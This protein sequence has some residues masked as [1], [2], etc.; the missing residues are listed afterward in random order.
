[1]EAVAEKAGWGRPLPEGRGRGIALTL[2][3]QTYAAQVVEVSLDAEGKVRTE[4][5]VTVVDCGR[6]VSP[7][8]V[9][10]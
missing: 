10:A 6:V 7:A 4:R 9:E 1:L 8:T 3:F 5:V 2:A